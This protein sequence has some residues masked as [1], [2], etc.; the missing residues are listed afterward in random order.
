MY[1]F[2]EQRFNISMFIKT[3]EVVTI[4]STVNLVIGILCVGLLVSMYTPNTVHAAEDDVGFGVGRIYGLFP[5][6][7]EDEIT[8]FLIGPLLGKATLDSNRFSGYL[9]IFFIIGD[10]QWRVNVPPSIP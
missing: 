3:P 1:A 4:V 10:Y 2:V 8:C 5:S 7:S 6:V 9:G